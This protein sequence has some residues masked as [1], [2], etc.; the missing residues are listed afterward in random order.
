[1]RLRRGPIGVI[2]AGG[3][4]R[5]IGGSKAIVKLRGRPLI[6]YALEAMASVLGEVAVIAKPDTELPSLSGVAIWIEP[7]APQHPV[8]GI[9]HALALAH[10]RPVFICAADLPLVTPALIELIAQTNPAG[11]A[12]VV[13]SH[14]GAIQPLLGCYQ[15]AAAA[16]LSS[17]TD[18]PLRELV[19]AIGPR[20]F[21]VPDPDELFNVNSPDDLLQATAMLDQRAR[22]ATRT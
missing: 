21:E 18:R 7:E 6:V 1:M 15:P 16:R 9:K 10:G 12:A 13:A 22:S 8:M 19:G 14:A 20:L 2:L 11:A 4:G 3:Q 5:R 17:A